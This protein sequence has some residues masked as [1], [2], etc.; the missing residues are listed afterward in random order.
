MFNN[1]IGKNKELGKFLFCERYT[2]QPVKN[3]MYIAEG[4]ELKRGAVVDVNGVLVGTNSLMPYAVLEFDCDTR[5]GGKQASVFTKGEFN[6]DKLSF[7]SGLSN[8]DIDNIIFNGNSIGIVI[9]P[10]TY[11]KSFTPSNNIA[12]NYEKQIY[13]AKSYVMHGG[14]LYTNPNAINTAEDWNPAHWT[15][16]TVAQMVAGNSGNTGY[17]QRNINVGT[18]DGVHPVTGVTER[19]VTIATASSGSAI[20]WSITIDNDCT[21]AVVILKY[22]NG[23]MYMKTISI[24][25]DDGRSLTLYGKIGQI[26]AG[27]AEGDACS[28]ELVPYFNGINGEAQVSE[29][30]IRICGDI[31]LLSFLLD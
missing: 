31:A 28:Y 15:V 10:Y 27:S 5:N 25:R 9:K 11:E 29:V 3:A 12:P 16:T 26:V 19:S 6:F 1:L 4:Q 14:V 22:V 20:P 8:S 23:D 2:L 24:K 17:K 13:P 21:D 30:A 18:E 7:A